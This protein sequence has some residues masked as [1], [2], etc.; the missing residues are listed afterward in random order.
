MPR[1]LPLIVSLSLLAF[2]LASLVGQRAVTLVLLTGNATGHA[3]ADADPDRPTITPD[4]PA[5]WEVAVG[6]D[7]RAWRAALS[8][9]HARADLAIRGTSSAV[10][11]RSA[12][13]SWSLGLDVGRRLAGHPDG[14]TLHALLGVAIERTT[15]P[16]TGGDPRT[17]QVTRLTLEGAVPF[18]RHWHAVV[19]GDG[20]RS[21]AIF[22]A[23]ELPPGYV[24]RAGRRWNLGV[25]LRW[26]P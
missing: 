10:L 25:G 8:L 17:V 23:N 7:H 4:H 18:T 21:A 16:V 13:R 1:L 6:Q 11:T 2:P 20:G 15:F 5:S 14:P 12:I 22:G 24:V 19:R 3:R 26:R 9:R